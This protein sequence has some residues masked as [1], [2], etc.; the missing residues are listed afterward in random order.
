MSEL[1]DKQE[2]AQKREF[3][4]FSGFTQALLQAHENELFHNYFNILVSGKN[5]RNKVERKKPHVFKKFVRHVQKTCVMD[6]KQLQ[7]NNS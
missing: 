3:G 5:A 2:N 6:I 4:K 1:L 7:V